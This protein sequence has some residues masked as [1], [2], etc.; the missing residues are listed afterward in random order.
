L[1]LLQMENVNSYYGDAHVLHNVNLNVFEG[2]IISL[3][4]R[5]GVGKSTT[6]KS[7]MGM[8]RVEGTVLFKGEKVT[9]LPTSKIA[10]R[11]IGLV[12]EERRIFANLTIKENLLVGVSRKGYWNLEKVYELFPV[13]KEKQ[14]RMGTLLSGGEQQMLAIARCIMTNPNIIL[15]DE[16]CEGLA[17]VIVNELEKGIIRLKEEGMTIIIAE[18]SLRLS[19]ALASRHY[20]ISKGEICF[21]GTSDQL[22]NNPDILI[23][24]LGVH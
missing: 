11:G 13:L 19:K 2:E 1:S 4:G 17:P 24:Y 16:P 7:I 18:Q 14:N 10:R 12:P 15:L 22:F 20:L 8:L 23:Q 3:L 21:E 5:N 9:S 6:L